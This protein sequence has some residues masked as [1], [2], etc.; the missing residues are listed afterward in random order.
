MVAG[1]INWLVLCEDVILAKSEREK[2]CPDGVDEVWRVWHSKPASLCVCSC[3]IDSNSLYFSPLDEH[4]SIEFTHSGKRKS[5]SDIG[6]KPIR[7]RRQWCIGRRQLVGFENGGEFYWHCTNI[8][9]GL[10]K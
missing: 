2:V 10:D 5:R 7:F 4:K 6:W 9:N 1:K 8:L 3:S